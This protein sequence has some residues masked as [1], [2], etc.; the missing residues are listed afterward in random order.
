[1]PM[2]FSRQL[3]F[4]GFRTRKTRLPNI[5]TFEMFIKKLTFWSMNLNQVPATPA[6]QICIVV[7]EIAGFYILNRNK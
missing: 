6:L 7:R 1:M 3:I 2:V 4:K 5:E